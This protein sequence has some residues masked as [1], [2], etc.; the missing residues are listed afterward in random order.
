MLSKMEK[1]LIGIKDKG[2]VEISSNIYKRH[3]DMR[4]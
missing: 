4:M 2:K 1:I 3:I